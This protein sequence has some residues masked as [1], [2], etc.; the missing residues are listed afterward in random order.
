MPMKDAVDLCKKRGVVPVGSG[1][2]GTDTTGLHPVDGAGRPWQAYVF[3]CQVAE[4]EVDTVTGEVQVLGIWAAHNE[5][6][7]RF[8][9]PV[10]DRIA[11]IAQEISSLGPNGTHLHCEGGER[12]RAGP[13]PCFVPGVPPRRSFTLLSR[14]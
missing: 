4:V 9:Q 1:S 6:L 14:E 2:F 8:L 13:P 10:L 12:K 7:W 5:R 3:G 11:T